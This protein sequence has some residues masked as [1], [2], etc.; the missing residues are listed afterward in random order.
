[1]RKS[2]WL[3]IALVYACVLIAALAGGRAMGWESEGPLM[4]VAVVV[5]VQLA[6]WLYHRRYAEAAPIGLR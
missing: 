3:L 5:A 4:V 6:A 2:E 1:M